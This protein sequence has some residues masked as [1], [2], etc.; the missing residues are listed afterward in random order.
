MDDVGLV[1]AVLDLTGFGF[2]DGVG[3]VRRDRAGLRGRHETLGAEHLTET[4]DNA[5][6]VGRGDDGVE[7]EPVLTLDLR[8]EILAAGVIGTG[9]ERFLDL[10]FLAEDEHAGD[11]AGAVGQDDGAADLLVGVTGVN[12]Q[13]HVQLDGLVELGLGGLGDEL[14]GFLRLVLSLLI[15]ELSALFI[16]FTSEQFSFLLIKWFVGWMILPRSGSGI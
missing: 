16:I 3:N 12:A 8:N 1:E 7:L 6:H 13:L 14:E 4:A 2:L 10:L 15:N 5:H 11:L 9:V